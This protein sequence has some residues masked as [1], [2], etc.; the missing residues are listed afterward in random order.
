MLVVGGAGTDVRGVLGRVHLLFGLL[1]ISQD[2]WAGKRLLV[3]G[4]VRLLPNA[5]GQSSAG[6]SDACAAFFF[7]AATI[8]FGN[9][10]TGLTWLVGC[11]RRWR[12]PGFFLAKFSP[13]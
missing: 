8:V 5:A 13:R 2:F 11:L 1:G 3:V 10:C 12:F 6:T 7:L 4:L 9:C